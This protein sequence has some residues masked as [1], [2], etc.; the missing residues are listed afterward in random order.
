M[1]DNANSN[2]NN[3]NN[4]RQN[5]IFS[6]FTQPTSTMEA[7][8]Q[9]QGGASGFQSPV[10]GQNSLQGKGGVFNPNFLNSPGRTNFL[11]RQ[12]VPFAGLDNNN[13]QGQG[14]VNHSTQFRKPA[15]F[16]KKSNIKFGNL[17]SAYPALPGGSSR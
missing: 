11:S 15:S 1:N 14:N 4:N 7:G 6:L 17:C 12:V 8:S 10:P 5:S 9:P 2:S 3:N 16:F 13:Q